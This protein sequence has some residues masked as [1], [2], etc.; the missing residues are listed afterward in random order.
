MNVATPTSGIG[1][2]KIL[3]IMKLTLFLTLFVVTSVFANNTFSQN[4]LLSLE[5]RNITVEKV[6]LSIEDQSRFVFIYNKDLIDVNRRVDVKLDNASVEEILDVVFENAGVKYK[7]INNQIALSPDYS[8][9]SQPTSVK[10]KITD[11]AGIPLPGVTIVIKGT[12]QGT[13]TDSD[14]NYSLDNIPADAVLSVSF[15]GMLTQEVPVSGKGV[16]DVSLEEETIGLE[17]VVAIGYGTVKKSDLTGAVSSV[18][19][20]DLEKATPV[21]VQSA[22]QGRA[23]GIMVSSN[24]GAPGT[25]ASIRIRGMGTVN[26]NN[27]IYVV[28]GMIVDNSDNNGED[29]DNLAKNLN[30]LNPSD[31]ESV[32]VL[33][34]ASAQAIYG[35]RGANGVIL[36]T[37]RKGKEGAPKV[38][39]SSS[40]GITSVSSLGKLLGAKDYLDY[41]LT[42][43]YNGYVRSGG[44]ESIDPVNINS[45]TQ[46]AKAL[47]DKGYNTDWMDEILSNAVSQN[48]N[49]A[50]RGGSQKA[51]YSVSAGYLNEEG[52]IKKSGYERYSFRLNT[53]YNLGKFIKIGENLGITSSQTKQIAEDLGG[54]ISNAMVVDPLT[55]VINED[56]DESDVNYKYNKYSVAQIVSGSENP[57]SILSRT[58]TNG[59]GLSIV[60][61]VFAEITILKDLKFRSSWGFNKSYN[62]ISDFDPAYYL[63]AKF[64]RA[65][66]KVSL[67]SYRS[68]EWVL[69]NTLSYNK[70]FNDHTLS[71][72]VGYTREHS[73]YTFTNAA[74]EGTASNA[75]ELW[76]FSAATDNPSVTGSYSNLAMMSYLGRINYSY[77]DKYIATASFRRDGSSKF[78][79]G[80][81]WGSF[82]SFSLGWRLISEPF[83]QN[84][85]GNIFSNFKIR[86]GWGQIGN[87]SLPVYNAYV[88][89]VGTAS[90]YRYLY[91]N[92]QSPGYYLTTIG[93]PDISWETTK[94]LNLGV[95]M[96]FLKNALTVSADYYTK[97]TE[98]MLLQI[99]Y[100]YYAG[101]PST[102]SPYSNAGS[103]KNKGFEIV[104][105]YQGKAG[106]LGYGISANGGIFDNEV[107]D[108]GSGQNPI[109]GDYQRTELHNSIGRFYG[110]VTDGIFQTEEEVQQYVSANGTVLQP[111][112]H[113]GDFRFKNLNGDDDINANDKTFIGN[114]LPEFTYGLTLNLSWKAFDFTA[115]FQGSYGNDIYNATLERLGTSAGEYNILQSVYDN[116]WRGEGTSNSQPI[117]STVNENDNYRI[118]DYFIEDGSYLRLKNVQLGYNLPK[119]VC[120]KFKISD[121]RIFIG[122]TDLLTF[123]DYSG[124]DPEVGQNG[125]ATDGLGVDAFAPYPKTRKIT[126][127]FN[128]SF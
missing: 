47:Y 43:Y 106:K 40:I 39:F 97:N 8:K 49:I 117:M 113:A 15:V 33:K 4:R 86:S 115:F 94:Q 90:G 65:L 21:N 121:A 128:V 14:G 103:V 84:F 73:H 89:Q 58:N 12:T 48:Y 71:A 27:P 81:K 99:S 18:R 112:A 9:N 35:S 45:T 116:A 122:G 63:S 22:L 54:A 17:E 62:D 85:A 28:D 13:I 74:K 96:G 10:G 123:T 31:I 2:R 53:D 32:E 80:H 57:A 52:I 120:S 37:T 7:I 41:L 67:N 95:D 55:P 42:A 1:V 77:K 51:R 127:G 82:P 92:T 36:I 114:P 107:T 20:E 64:S 68:D 24:S 111:D 75:R 30:F 119:S 23:A 125:T 126:F 50:I 105:D 98:D 91:N 38:T 72:V 83:F 60:G 26:N 66:S 93:T 46:K 25:E 11:V 79:D 34:D 29:G 59:E 118:S 44:D 5:M 70:T 19:S 101:Y 88:S 76:T 108:L 56:A 100:P 104:I 6:L 109:I 102:A 78:G 61:N 110:Y 69:E 124:N 3:K 87:S 16:I